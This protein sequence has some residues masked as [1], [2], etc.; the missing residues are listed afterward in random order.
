MD[1]CLVMM[2][3]M[4][5]MMAMIRSFTLRTKGSQEEQETFCQMKKRRKVL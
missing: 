5:V 4:M 3:V 1:I 2:M